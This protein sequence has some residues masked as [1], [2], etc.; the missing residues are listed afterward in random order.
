MHTQTE[1]NRGRLYLIAFTVLFLA[2]DVVI[3]T[4][5]IAYGTI[6]WGQIGGTVLSFVIC[7]FIW[8]GARYAYWFMAF[9][10]G[11]YV[12]LITFFS[13][14]RIPVHLVATSIYGGIL[15]S[16]LLARDTRSFLRH[17]RSL[18]AEPAAVAGI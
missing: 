11:S 13:G 18:R 12:I 14:A 9:C 5:A 7:W 1:N 3:K 15:L 16:L 4:L 6:S 17:R 10:L 2:A 8:R